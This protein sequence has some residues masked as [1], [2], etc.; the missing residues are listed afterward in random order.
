MSPQ[1]PEQ[2]GL[3]PVQSRALAKSGSASLAKRGLRSLRSQ[4]PLIYFGLSPFPQRLIQLCRSQQHIPQLAPHLLR[5]QRLLAH[6]RVRADPQL[7]HRT[8]VF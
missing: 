5:F 1:T 6:R 2:G 7:G 4:E 8:S 3:E